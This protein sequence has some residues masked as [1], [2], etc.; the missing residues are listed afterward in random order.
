LI[1]I[2]RLLICEYRHVLQGYLRRMQ[3]MTRRI[4]VDDSAQVI[5]IKRPRIR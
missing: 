3:A 5:Y 1:C 2:K 4:C